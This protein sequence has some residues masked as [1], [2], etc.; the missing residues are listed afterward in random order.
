MI[1][2]F[3]K[4][5]RGATSIEYALIASLIGA[6]IVGGVTTLGTATED[7]YQQLGQEVE[8]ATSG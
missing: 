2:K 5:N 3:L 8:N 7:N 4:D 1:K 6:A